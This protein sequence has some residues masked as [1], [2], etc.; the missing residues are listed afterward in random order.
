MSISA[1]A[2]EAAY[3]PPPTI[4][5]SADVRTAVEEVFTMMDPLPPA[6]EAIAGICVC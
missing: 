4:A 6:V 5:G 2:L 1:A 3:M